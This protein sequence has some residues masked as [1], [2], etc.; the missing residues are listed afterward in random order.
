MFSFV[1][2]WPRNQT[3]TVLYLLQSWQAR[4]FAEIQIYYETVYRNIGDNYIYKMTKSIP[5]TYQLQGTVSFCR[6][7]CVHNV[8]N[9]DL[10][11]L[12][13]ENKI[14]LHNVML[15]ENILLLFSYKKI[16]YGNNCVNL[17]KKGK[18]GNW[19]AVFLSKV[20]L[21]DVIFPSSI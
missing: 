3:Y 15:T 12:F 19:F 2:S 7:F 17:R 9:L 21:Y 16:R 4:F 14:K 10:I 18:I 13:I 6:S 8:Q 11:N 1:N 5:C 20:T